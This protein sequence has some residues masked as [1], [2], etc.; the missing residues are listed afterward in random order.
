MTLVDDH[1]FQAPPFGYR[2]RI[3]RFFE[4]FWKG[5]KAK[6]AQ[7]EL[8][9]WIGQRFEEIN[10]VTPYMVRLLVAQYL[11]REECPIGY[12]QKPTLES[13]PKDKIILLASFFYDT[14]GQVE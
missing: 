10:H 8:A 9:L 13:F 4:L 5:S 12:W 7:L 6:N 14:H 1:Y 11:P 2:L 3:N